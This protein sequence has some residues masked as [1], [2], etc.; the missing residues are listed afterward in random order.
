MTDEAKIDIT[1]IDFN[2]WRRH[3]VTELLHRYL[4]DYHEMILKDTMARWEGGSLNLTDEHERRW[5]AVVSREIADLEYEAIRTF[6]E[7]E[8]EI[9]TE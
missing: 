6:Y 9:A 7:G 2:L 8:Q 5:R 4:R 3:P 1:E